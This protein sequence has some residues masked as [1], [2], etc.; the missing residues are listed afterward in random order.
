MI[1]INDVNPGENNLIRE[2]HE[3]KEILHP[4]DDLA[5]RVNFKPLP[6]SLLSKI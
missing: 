5:T 4:S 6:S 3:L 2:M 1:N